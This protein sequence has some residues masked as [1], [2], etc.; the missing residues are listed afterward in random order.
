MVHLYAS[1][2]AYLPFFEIVRK[3]C[4]SCQVQHDSRI[5]ELASKNSSQ[6]P[7]LFSGT[8][9]DDIGTKI[10]GLVV[11]ACSGKKPIYIDSSKTFFNFV[12]LNDNLKSHDGQRH[13]SP[14]G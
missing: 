1:T 2:F 5:R 12:L 13:E 8:D 9:G 6:H 10:C 3:S 14:D 11:G 4:L 7:E